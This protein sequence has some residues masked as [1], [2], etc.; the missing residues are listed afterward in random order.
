LLRAQ[1][2]LSPA[3]A[4]ATEHDLSIKDTNA[5]AQVLNQKLR[6]VDAKVGWSYWYGLVG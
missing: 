2:R 4:G 3:S 6:N 5:A 1:L